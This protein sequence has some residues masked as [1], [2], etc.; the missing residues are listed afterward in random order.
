VGYT[1]RAAYQHPVFGQ[2]FP[3]GT[4]PPGLCPNAEHMVPR[5]VLGYTMV[6][7]RSAERAAHALRAAIEELS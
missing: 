6:P 1:N 4:Y 2:V 5:M 7:L 3:K